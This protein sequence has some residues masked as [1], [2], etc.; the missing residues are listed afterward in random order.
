MFVV[1]DVDTG[2]YGCRFSIGI[3]NAHDKSMRLAMALRPKRS[4][5]GVAGLRDG[6]HLKQNVE[7][8]KKGDTSI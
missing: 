5:Y 3:R 8:T 1:L 2:M 4:A 6:G 7:A